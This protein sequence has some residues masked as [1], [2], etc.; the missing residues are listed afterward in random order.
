MKKQIYLLPIFSL[1]CL[2]LTGCSSEDVVKTPTVENKYDPSKPRVLTK[3]IPE[4]GGFGDNCILSGNF[5]ADVSKMKVIFGANKEAQIISSDGISIYCLVP[6]LTDGDNSVK[7]VV[8]DEELTTDKKFAYTQVQKVTTFCGVYNKDGYTNGSIFSALFKRVVSINVVAGDNIVAVETHDKHVRLISQE[9][10]QVITIMDGLCTGKPA[11][12]AARDALYCV[13]LYRN[14]GKVYRLRRENNWAPELLRGNI[15]ELGTAGEQWSC[16]LDGTEKYLYI[17]NNVGILVRVCLEEKASDGQL[18]VET[19]LQENHYMSGGTY[20]WMIY[21]PIDN[22]FFASESFNNQI[23]KI[24]EDNGVWK[25]EIY[26]GGTNRAGFTDGGRLEE[27]QFNQPYGMTV[28]SEGNLYIADKGNNAIRKVSHA[29][30]MVTTVAGGTKSG[31]FEV[32]GLPSEATFLSP[33]DIAVDSE[34][35]FYIAGGDARNIRKLAIE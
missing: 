3:F 6:K 4:K 28:D 19:L 23:R 34:D 13:E 14:S 11:V 17:R 8:G 33:H 18:K 31:D 21:S 30:G 32:D 27:A 26:A 29:N 22:C 24:W 7:V 9:D 15:K 12:N 20:N 2:F 10:N 25:D 5:G 16:A 1:F 35:N